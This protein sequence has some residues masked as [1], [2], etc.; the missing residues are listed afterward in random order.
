MK[1]YMFMTTDVSQLSISINGTVD[2][3]QISKQNS[4]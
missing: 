4:F 1:K 3:H 2:E